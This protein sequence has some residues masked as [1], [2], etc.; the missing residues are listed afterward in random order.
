MFIVV[1]HRLSGN[2]R[3]QFVKQDGT[4]VSSIGNGKGKAPPEP[5]KETIFQTTHWGAAGGCG[6]QHGMCASAER[7]TLTADLVE[8]AASVTRMNLEE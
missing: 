5:S 1:D 3:L 2:H 7:V 4:F 8:A 6:G